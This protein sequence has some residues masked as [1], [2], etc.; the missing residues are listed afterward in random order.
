VRGIISLEV[1]YLQINNSD[2]TFNARKGKDVLLVFPGK[3]RA[4]NPQ[5]P[6]SM[7][8]LASWLIKEGFK[9]SIFDM[10][11]QNIED[12]KLGNPVLV[13]ITSMS[14]FQIKYGIEFAKKVRAEQPDT[15]IVWG[16][17]HPTLLPEQTVASQYVDVVVRG[18]GEAT[19]ADLAKKLSEKQPIDNVLGITFKRNNQPVSTTDREFINLDEL[20]TSLPY[21]L[22]DVARYPSLKAGRVHLQTS[23][24][25][26]H[27]CGFCY[28]TIFNKNQWR[29]K[30]SE[31]ILL[32]IQSLIEQFPNIKCL[33]FIDDNFFVSKQ[34]VVEICRGLIEKKIGKTWRA[35]CRF[36]YFA[37]YDQ[38]FVSLLEQSGCVELNFGAETGSPRLLEMIKKDET[39]Q[40]MVS[41][42]GKLKSW[43][44]TIEPYI[45]WMNGYP[46]ETKEDLYETFKVQEEMK[47][48]NNLTQHIETCVFTPF[49]S[50]MFM[51]LNP[52]YKL[53]RSL[54]EWANMD[55]FHFRPPW[56][57]KKYVKFL[58]DVSVV[59]RYNFFPRKR[60]R[61]MGD[62]YYAGYW[63]FNKEAAFRLRHKYFSYAYGLKLVGYLSKKFRG[64]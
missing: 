5:V 50:P 43:A 48:A 28:N 15:P 23:R 18:E 30:S 19:I 24:G 8:F 6:L 27:R 38:D 59:T 47:K 39:P 22:L 21:N 61:E 32:E 7:L 20:P 36:D 16:G 40:M 41:A 44:P 53:P 37:D 31:N 45:F 55:V 4:P 11:L 13:G 25:C 52:D 3:Y 1:S 57:T 2:F 9:P 58:G 46:T 17:V 63:I 26:P 35:D 56:H 12:Y 51:Q 64:Y 54:E 49:P 33:D 60:I 29:T 14:G 62:V 34:R 10:R 42:L